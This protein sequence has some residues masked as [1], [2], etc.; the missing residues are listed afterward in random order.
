MARRMGLTEVRAYACSFQ[1]LGRIQEAGRT[2][3]R[4]FSN[5]ERIEQMR[6]E[7]LTKNKRQP[8]G[9]ETIMIVRTSVTENI[10]LHKPSVSALRQY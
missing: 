2:E 9:P 5:L 1:R 6:Q 7:Q 8:G 10:A 3:P 4:Y